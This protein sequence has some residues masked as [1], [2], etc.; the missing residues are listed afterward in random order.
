[1]TG[2]SRRHRLAD[3]AYDLLL[4]TGQMLSL[5]PFAPEELQERTLFMHN[6]RD[7]GVA[8]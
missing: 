1:M 2:I 8:V 4:E 3:L 6:L 7:E 5:K